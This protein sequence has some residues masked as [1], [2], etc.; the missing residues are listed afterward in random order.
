MKCKCPKCKSKL[1]VVK[2]SRHPYLKCPSCEVVMKLKPNEAKCYHCNHEIYYYKHQ[3]KAP[4]NICKC[5]HCGGLNKLN[6]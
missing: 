2:Q 5:N 6:S 3:F 1:S 4:N